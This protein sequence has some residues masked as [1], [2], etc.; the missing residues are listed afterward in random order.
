MFDPRQFSQLIHDTLIDLDHQLYSLAAVQLLLGT[1]A[2]ESRL[3]TYLAQI[4]GPALGVFQMEPATETDIWFNFISYRHGL[5]NAV[6]LT[7]HV[8]GPSSLDLRGN[9]PYQIAMARLHYYRVPDPLPEAGDIE[10]MAMY[11][12]R[13]YNTFL[14][15]GTTDEFVSNYR[16][17]VGNI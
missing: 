9:L 12:K 1:S 3:G 7:T 16:R 5:A 13:H 8:V 15:R 10:S 6:E 17:H 2:Q 14:G 4:N 11:W